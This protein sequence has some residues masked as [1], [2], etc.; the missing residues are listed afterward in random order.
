MDEDASDVE[1]VRTFHERLARGEEE[2]IPAEF[3]NRMIDGENLV[4]VWREHRGM[5]ARDLA[6]KAG[7]SVEELARIEGGEPAG[8]AIEAIAA[9]LRLTVDELT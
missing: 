5:T 1:A 7:I 4:K 2:L 8:H 6:E 9:A 3:V